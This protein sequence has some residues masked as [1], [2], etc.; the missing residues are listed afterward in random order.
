[1]KNLFE[2]E[3]E[4]DPKGR[5]LKRRIIVGAMVGLVVLA[6]T[7]HGVWNDIAGLVKALKWW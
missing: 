3:V 1:M 6:L 2:Y 7:G 5:P 4:Y